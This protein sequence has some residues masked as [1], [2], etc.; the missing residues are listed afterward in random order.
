MG[1]GHGG[2]NLAEELIQLFLVSSVGLF[3]LQITH[4]KFASLLNYSIDYFNNRAQKFFVKLKRAAFSALSVCRLAVDP[5]QDKAH[6][7][8]PQPTDDD[9]VKLRPKI[10]YG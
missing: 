9:S 1:I 10:G 3:V 5:T 4:H 6:N 2:R 8:Q 7:Q